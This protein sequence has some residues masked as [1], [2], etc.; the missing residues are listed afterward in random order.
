MLGA[1][2]QSNGVGFSLE[3]ARGLTWEEGAGGNEA[4]SL[5]GNGGDGEATAGELALQLLRPIRHP[6]RPSLS[7]SAPRT[8]SFRKETGESV[9]RY[10]GPAISTE[11]VHAPFQAQPIKHVDF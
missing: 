2:Q 10:H 4:P 11:Y 8:R 5:S 6:P 9:R 1:Q 7:S 3:R